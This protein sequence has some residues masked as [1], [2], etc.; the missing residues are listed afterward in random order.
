[1]FD[2]YYKRKFSVTDVLNWFFKPKLPNFFI[3]ILVLF[4]IFT[5]I[6]QF[7]SYLFVFPLRYGF[8][9]TSEI[10]HIL[11]LPSSISLFFEQMWSVL[12]FIFI[13]QN[14]FEFI[15]SILII[16]LFG[17]I[18]TEFWYTRHFL[19]ILF[20]SLF[21]A[22]IS[23]IIFGEYLQRFEENKFY[24]SGATPFALTLVGFIWA[25]LP[26]YVF[27]FLYFI[28][29][30]IHFVIVIVLL[31][32]IFL[33][34][35]SAL[36]RLTYLTCTFAGAILGVVYRWLQRLLHKQKIRISEKQFL[37]D[38][39]KTK[40]D[41]E[42]QKIKKARQDEID[43]ILDKISKYGYD[44]LTKEEKEFLFLQRDH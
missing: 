12:T 30:S 23:F 21:I 26:R 16:I 14:F 10:L 13:P 40:T 15:F 1:M 43:R 39:V 18:F 22:S 41:Q 36:H 4:Y 35:E 25:T 7:I 44:S 11:H 29:L 20:F 5:L 6:F 32:Q 37:T 42:Y 8:D 28:K 31:V 2:Y 34:S 19:L 24:L 17:K 33:V 38:H 9:K 27:S 3:A